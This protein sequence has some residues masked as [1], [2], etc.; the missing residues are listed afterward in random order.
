[1]PALRAVILADFAVPSGGAQRVALESARALAEAGVA[2]TYLHATGTADPLLHHPAIET[3]G[4]GLS[5]VWDLPRA[6]GLAA[7]LWNRPAAARVGQALAAL[8]GGPKVLHLHQWTRAF[9]PAILPACLGSGLPVVVTLHDYFAACPNGVFYRFDRD[10]PCDRRPLSA[11]CLV[12]PCDPR[13]RATKAVRV[14][15]TALTRRALRGPLDFVHVSDRGRRTI[16][17][18]LPPARHHRVDNPVAVDKA[19][20]AA[21]APDG[22]VAYVGRLT[23]EKGADLV[24][25]AA[26]AAGIPSL[27]VGEGPLA[28]EIRRIDPAAQ[29]L[30][31][32]PPEEVAAL[33]RTRARALVAPSRWYETGPLTVYEAMAQGLPVV[34]S[35]RAGAA[36]KV[37]HGVTGLVVPP[38]VEALAD[39]FR[40]LDPALGAAAYARY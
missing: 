38:T 31:W 3:I 23:R 5:D 8:P 21:P 12:A 30:G 14:I 6:Q 4:L 20:P 17:P 19:P 7:G 9:S 28:D 2:V 32:R 40:C 37:L 36:E 33:L 24:A 13:G 26:R 39:A 18:F 16:E 10:E 11:A 27:F 1:M 34:V 35:E 29:V 22:P 25:Q 15:R